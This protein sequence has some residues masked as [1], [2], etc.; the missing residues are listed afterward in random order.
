M[1]QG[2]FAV[3]FS[4]YDIDSDGARELVNLMLLRFEEKKKI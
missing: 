3:L 4:K 2:R 1:M